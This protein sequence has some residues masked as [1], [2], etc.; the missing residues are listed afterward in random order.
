LGKSGIVFP[1][2][3]RRQLKNGKSVVLNVQHHAF[4]GK[5]PRKP[6]ALPGENTKRLAIVWKFGIIMG[7][8]KSVSMRNGPMGGEKQWHRSQRKGSVLRW[9]DG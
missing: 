8:I 1:G 6:P 4:L 9:G 2:G 3:P 5:M 7:N